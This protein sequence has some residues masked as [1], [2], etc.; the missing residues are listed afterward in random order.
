MCKTNKEKCLSL[1]EP[2]GLGAT[3]DESAE[4][5]LNLEG[6]SE[7]AIAEIMGCVSR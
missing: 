1:F 5:K 7:Q 6:N 2:L 4:L 3:S